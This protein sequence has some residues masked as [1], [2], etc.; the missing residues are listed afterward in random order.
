[1]K[2]TVQ[3]SISGPGLS[4]F[5]PGGLNAGAPLD[6]CNV[7]GPVITCG[8]RELKAG[9]TMTLGYIG[10]TRVSFDQLRGGAGRIGISAYILAPSNFPDPAGL[11][12][13]QLAEVVVCAAGATDPA[14]K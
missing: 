1:M 11:N 14:C 4:L 10:G 7:E 5:V 3:L 13:R 2:G 12:N 8:Y 9:Q 6:D